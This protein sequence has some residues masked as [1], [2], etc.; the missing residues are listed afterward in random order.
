MTNSLLQLA[1]PPVEADRLAASSGQIARYR[2]MAF[3]TGVVLLVGTVALILKAAGVEHLEPGTGYLWLGHG[4]L[5][6]IYVVITLLLGMRLRWP[7]PRFVIVMLAGTIPTASFIAEHYVTR[8][9]RAAA[10]QPVPSR[11]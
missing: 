2:F 8:A 7:L 3:A 6:L 5:Y 1:Q 11:D 4:Y 10:A 9:A